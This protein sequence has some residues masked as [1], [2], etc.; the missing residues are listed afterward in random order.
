MI[1]NLFKNIMNSLRK[2]YRKDSI[3]KFRNF[4]SINIY[5]KNDK[6]IITIQKIKIIQNKFKFKYS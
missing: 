3:K 6:S 1:F 4:I 5:K 2:L